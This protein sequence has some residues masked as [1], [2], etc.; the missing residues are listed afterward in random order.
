MCKLHMNCS[1]LHS[2]TTSN[3]CSQFA[4]CRLTG[5]DP[6]A[7][8]SSP[9]VRVEKRLAIVVFINQPPLASIA[10]NRGNRGSHEDIIQWKKLISGRYLTVIFSLIFWHCVAATT[11]GF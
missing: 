2:A 6:N 4:F 1:W 11:K 3:S 7:S 5:E 8:G 9:G 10:T